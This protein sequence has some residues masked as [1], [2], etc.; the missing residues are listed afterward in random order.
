MQ[1]AI[2]SLQSEPAERIVETL[3]IPVKT[4]ILN[5]D[6]IAQIRLICECANATYQLKSFGG[7]FTKTYLLEINNITVSSALSIVGQLLDLMEETNG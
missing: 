5:E 4:G 7:W 3:R 2:T 1:E 6:I